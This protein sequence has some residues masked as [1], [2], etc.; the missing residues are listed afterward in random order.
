MNLV[1]TSESHEINVFD[2]T[3]LYILRGTT[4]QRADHIIIEHYYCINLF[5]IILNTQLQ[6][7]NKRFCNNMVIFYFEFNTLDVF[8][9]FMDLS[10]FYL[11]EFIEQEKFDPRIYML[12]IM[13]L[14]SFH[15]KLRN[16]AK[17]YL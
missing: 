4:C 3:T 10:K 13:N 5:N 1:F 12:I 14:M 6:E 8:F 11:D 16:I 2:M 15:S 9:L 17:I 7:L